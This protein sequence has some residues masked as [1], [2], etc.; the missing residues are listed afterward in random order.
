MRITH[1]I[2]IYKEEKKGIPLYVAVGV[3][4]G[5]MGEWVR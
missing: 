3:R 1:T 5:R 4:K 2:F